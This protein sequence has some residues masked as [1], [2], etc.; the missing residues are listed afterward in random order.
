VFYIWQFMEVLRGSSPL[1]ATAQYVPV[2]FS[3]LC[4]AITTGYLLSRVKSSYIILASMTAFTLGAVVIATAPVDESY[5]TRLF[6]SLIIMPWGM[7]MSFPA[8]TIIL[9]NHVPKEH[10]G[11]A[12]SLVNTVINYSISIGLGIAGM[13]ESQVNKDGSHT[14]K[15]YRSAW[16]TGIGLSG[17]GI[18]L[19]TLYIIQGVGK[20]T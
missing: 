17:M 15:G 2:G 9:S 16:Y 7:D 1:S 18:V 6:I 13:V 11:I 20:R 12:A 8:G 4:A 3:G 19:S 10:Q 14:L 5:W